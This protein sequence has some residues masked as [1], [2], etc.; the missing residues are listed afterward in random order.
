MVNALVGVVTSQV[1]LGLSLVAHDGI[2]FIEDLS[3][4]FTRVADICWM[5]LFLGPM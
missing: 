5:D 1:Y 4:Q 3:P 2:I